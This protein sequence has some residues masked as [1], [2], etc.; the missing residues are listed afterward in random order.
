MFVFLGI[1]EPQL[2]RPRLSGRSIIRTCL[3]AFMHLNRIMVCCG[4]NSFG[5]EYIYK[6]YEYR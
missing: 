4:Y 1:V 2:S 5:Y 6:K 3:N